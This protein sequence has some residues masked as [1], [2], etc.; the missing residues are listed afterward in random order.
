MQR[1]EELSEQI[2]KVNIKIATA[3][4]ELEEIE[5]KY[6]RKKLE[7]RKYKNEMTGLKL[8]LQEL[9]LNNWKELHEE[10]KIKRIQKQTIKKYVDDPNNEYY[11]QEKK[12]LNKEDAYT[13]YMERNILPYLD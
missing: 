1:K 4:K 12:F 10:E 5:L 13:S 8:E 11:S 9:E 6:K 2:G 7:I 3:N